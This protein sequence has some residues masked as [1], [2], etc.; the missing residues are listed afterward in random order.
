MTEKSFDEKHKDLDERM[1]KFIEI[2][3][4]DIDEQKRA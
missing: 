1:K 2:I 4:E 3:K